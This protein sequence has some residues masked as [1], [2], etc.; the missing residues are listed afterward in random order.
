MRKILVGINDI[1]KRLDNFLFMYL[2]NV[3]KT[4]IYKLIRKKN[5]KVNNKKVEINYKLKENDVIYLFVKDDIFEQ[6]VKYNIFLN[7]SSDIDIVYEDR[8]VLIV[9]KPCGLICHPDKQNQV[10]CLINRIKKYLFNKNEYNFDKE[11]VFSPSLV[12]RID[13]NTSGLTIAAKNFESLKILNEK[14]KNKE[15]EKY[16]KC[17]VYGK[18]PKKEDIITG[19]LLK[20]A[21]NNKVYISKSMIKSSKFIKTKYKL[22]EYRNDNTSLLEIKLLTGRSHQIRAHLASIGNPIVGDKKYGHSNRIKSQFQLLLSY[23]IKFKFKSCAGILNYMNNKEI[24]IKNSD[25]YLFTINK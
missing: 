8:N 18:P 11:N 21:Q 25:E 4:L 7:S 17:L 13:R 1:S 6:K 20:D 2:K 12:N 23:K 22:L 10:D 19:F 14:I 3:P 16:Y 5:I 24:T 15:I 9:N